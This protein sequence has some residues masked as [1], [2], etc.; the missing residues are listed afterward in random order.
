MAAVQPLKIAI[1]AMGGEGGGVL[2]DWIVDLGEA[3]GWLAQTTSVPGVAQRTG[4]TIYYVE[5]YPEQQ[6]AAD[7]ASPVFALMPLPGDVDVVLASELMECGRAVQRGFVTPDR[8]TLV[9]ST[10]RVYSIAEKSAMGDGRVDSKA[11]IARAASAAKRFVRF[12]M[13]E[14]AEQNGS[15][16]SAVLFG[17]LAGTG[18][19]P[20]SRAQFE[21]TIE[22]GGVG[23]KPSLKA[24]DAAYRRAA[25]GAAPATAEAASMRPPPA[26]TVA[27]PEAA[28]LDGTVDAPAAGANAKA[29]ADADAD[30]E[31]DT[32]L[33]ADAEA[34]PALLDRPTTRPV[35]DG[36]VGSFHRPPRDARVQALLDRIEADFSPASHGLLREGVRRLIDY[37]DP[38][39]ASLYLDRLQKVAQLPHAGQGL[40]D[41]TARHL[42]LWMSY[43]DTVRVAALKIRS[44][45]FERVR[46]EVRAADD[47]VLAIDEYLHPRPQEIAETLPASIGR[48]IER[49]GPVRRFVERMTERGRVVTTSSLTGFV[50]LY[51]VA[52]MKRWRR[53]TTRFMAESAAIE[54]WL[55][56]IAETAPRNAELAVEI[57]Q[58]QRLVKGYSD[59]HE[60]GV[61]NFDTVMAAVERAGATLAPATLRELREAA[62]ADEHGV[63]LEAVLLQHAL[64]DAAPPVFVT[65]QR[66]AAGDVKPHAESHA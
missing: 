48:W 24:F 31:A 23:V 1:M 54:A 11:L 19:L 62:L 14:A 30:T 12:D 3:N 33:D 47:Q 58:C 41:E 65:P 28:A 32:D 55:R 64:A 39:Y 9:A 16:I 50:M 38:D 6:A 66:A 52:G 53:S 36:V 17:A 5:L 61:R 29:D 57:A 60:R 37:Q 20:F 56:R 13:A 27:A 59:T 51:A 26:E 46:S 18:V 21:A 4:A 63:K 45:R 35:G 49:P 43:E 7:G 25:S 15:V 44:T 22:R 8:T 42:A 2:A 40:L 34:D 10:H